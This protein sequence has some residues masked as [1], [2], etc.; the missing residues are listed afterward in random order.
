MTPLREGKL[1]ETTD[2]KRFKEKYFDE[3][4]PDWYVTY[5]GTGSEEVRTNVSNCNEFNLT[6]ME[7]MAEYHRVRNA[8]WEAVKYDYKR[9]TELRDM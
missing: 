9:F 5:W 4:F 8:L 2:N 3:A 7:M 1:M 6:D